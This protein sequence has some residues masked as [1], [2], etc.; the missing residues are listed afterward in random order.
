MYAAVNDR[1]TTAAELVRRGA[2]IN[3]KNDVRIRCSCA[4]GLR[5]ARLRGVQLGGRSADHD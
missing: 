1:T 2:D 3:A 5:W 4:R